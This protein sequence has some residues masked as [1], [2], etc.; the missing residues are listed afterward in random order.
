MASAGAL[1]PALA[2]ATP[3]DPKRVAR[4]RD[5]R[6]L[7]IFT[8]VLVLFYAVGLVLQ[9]SLGFSGTVIIIMYAPAFGALCA[10]YAGPGVLWWGRLTWWV[11]AGLLPVVAVLA[12]LLI[13]AGVG[14][15]EFDAAALR[16]S[17][18]MAPANI[19]GAAILAFGEELG[20]RGFLWPQLRVRMG[21]LATA[22]VMAVIWWVYHVPVVLMGDYGSVAGLPAFT[23]SLIGFVLFAG[24]ITER[25]RSVWPSVL[26]HG[27]WN[28]LAA[29]GFEA[30]DAQG[31]TGEGLV[32]EFGW[33]NAAAM[34]VLG[35]GFAWRHLASGR[36][37]VLPRLPAASD[38]ASAAREPS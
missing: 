4:T 3:I 26:G 31:F 5:V 38:V 32:G 19:A 35:V 6:R 23:V 34:L 29:A 1:L 21:F 37:A 8:S 9:P 16:S 28:A 30:S 13:A 22:A 2:P 12:V 10:R 25:S 17:L 20:W 14:W 11:L 33:L 15:V 7:V 24:V 18:L 27:A 36:G